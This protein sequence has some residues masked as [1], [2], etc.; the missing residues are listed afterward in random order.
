MSVMDLTAEQARVIG[1]LIE[2]AQTT[3]DNYPL[4]TNALTNACNQTT[5]RQPV[6]GY[7]EREVDALMLEL[8][9]M[10]LART[11][12]GSGHRVG[13]HKHV[14]DEALGLDGHEL[15]VLA[16]LLLRGPQT[17]NE[18]A[19][20]TE[21]YGDGPQGDPAAVDAA[22]DRL[23]DRAE[24]LVVRLARRSGEREP[25]IDQCWAATHDGAP[26]AEPP[27]PAPA[28]TPVPAPAAPDLEQRVAALEAALAEQTRRLDDLLGEGTGV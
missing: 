3:P 1:C 17:R 28:P 13:K 10:K 23:A 2:K 26:P 20:R 8:R 27:P 14:V 22:I 5:N 24:P 12:T 21:R 19:T 15:A 4:S 7:T 16:A 11:V 25:R 6:V 18:I 9:E